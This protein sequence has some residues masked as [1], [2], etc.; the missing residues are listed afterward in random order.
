M[1]KEGL[2]NTLSPLCHPILSLGV[3]H[4]N[5]PG[6]QQ[7]PH[8]FKAVKM[9]FRPVSDRQTLVSAKCDD[10]MK[11][12]AELC[13]CRG[14]GGVGCVCNDPIPYVPIKEHN[15]FLMGED[16]DR[17]K[18]EIPQNDLFFFFCLK[19]GTENGDK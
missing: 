3:T 19:K 16:V 9:L 17:T 2:S 7:G 8:V 1:I 18:G 6:Q 13:V 5:L 12:G 4:P 14:D 10:H 15:L 11:A